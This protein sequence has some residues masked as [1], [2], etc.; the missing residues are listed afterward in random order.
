MIYF[1]IIILDLD[2]SSRQEK[3]IQMCSKNGLYFINLREAIKFTDGEP[4][5]G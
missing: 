1:I 4:E 5:K 2:E 3:I